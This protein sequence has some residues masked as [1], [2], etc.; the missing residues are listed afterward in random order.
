MGLI[1]VIEARSDPEIVTALARAVW[2]KDNPG[3]NCP[4]DRTPTAAALAAWLPE[5][6]EAA[7]LEAGE[8]LAALYG[9]SD[10]GGCRWRP[11]RTVMGR[12]WRYNARTGEPQEI[13]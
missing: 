2:A 3:K 6:P 7:Q 11:G 1:L 12:T 10:G 4:P 9:L 13:P 5:C 8:R